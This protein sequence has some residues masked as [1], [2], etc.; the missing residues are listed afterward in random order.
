MC[1]GYFGIPFHIRKE[2]CLSFVVVK[3]EAPTKPATITTTRNNPVFF[4]LEVA[5]AAFAFY[6][7][8]VE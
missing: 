3:I 5:P 6:Y 2:I 7:L 4:F 1:G 8:N